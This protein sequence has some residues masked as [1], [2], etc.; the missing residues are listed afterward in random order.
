MTFNIILA[1]GG[2]GGHIFPALALKQELEA[3]NYNVILTGDSKFQKYQEFDNKH[4]HIPSANFSNK[5]ILAILKSCM[6]LAKGLLKSI[7]L[8]YNVKPDILIGFGGYA[9][10]PIILAAALM[11][12][13]IILHE[14]NTVIGKANKMMLWKAEFLTTG[15]KTIK[16]IPDKYLNKIIFTG[17]PIRT[18]IITSSESIK[19]K[20]CILVIGGSQGA[21][22]FSKMIPDMI[23]N[24]PQNIKEK[25]HIIQQVREEDIELIKTR[26]SKEN[27]SYEIKDFFNDMEKKFAL[28]NLAI[29]R[30][31]A[32][33]ISELIHVRLPAIFIPYP[34]SADGHQYYN[35]KELVDNKAGWLIEE[36]KESSVQLLQIIKSINFDQAILTQYAQNLS[37]LDQNGTDNITNLIERV[38]KYEQYT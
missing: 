17:N 35:A 20:F 19:D 22:I 25:L 30:A 36:N 24:L 5:S 1:T 2:T 8:I 28:A 26:Y 12:K 11:R 4:I 33:T 37:K 3:K 16:N 14:A 15:F 7:W 38:L 31:G 6:I 13:K 29:V 32:S 34:T 9:S 21:K 23:V 18:N 27:I 10:Y